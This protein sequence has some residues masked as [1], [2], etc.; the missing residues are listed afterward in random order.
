MAVWAWAIRG[1][2]Q[3]LQ[4]AE[5]LFVIISPAPTCSINVY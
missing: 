2:V 4:D 5:F 3:V 1:A